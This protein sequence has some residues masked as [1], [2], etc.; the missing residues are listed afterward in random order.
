VNK[1]LKNYKKD[2]APLVRKPIAHEYEQIKDKIVS[3][4]M[5]IRLLREE[6]ERLPEDLQMVVIKTLEAE[7]IQS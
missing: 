4:R 3:L 5:A 7:E 2:L 1:S 6:F